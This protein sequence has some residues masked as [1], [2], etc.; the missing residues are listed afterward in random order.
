[1]NGTSLGLW[2]VMF[3]IPVS[4]VGDRV[5]SATSSERSKYG[6]PSTETPSG[7][8]TLTDGALM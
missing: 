3:L 7:S 4:S 6:M 8:N 1:V 5:P 2:K